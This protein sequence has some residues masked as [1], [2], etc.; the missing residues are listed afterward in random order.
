VQASPDAPQRRWQRGAVLSEGGFA[1]VI[2]DPKFATGVGLVLF[3]A[4]HDPMF[5]GTLATA[6]DEERTGFGRKLAGWVR[7]MF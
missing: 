3:G 7:E 6:A 1:G 4:G 2:Q 5:S